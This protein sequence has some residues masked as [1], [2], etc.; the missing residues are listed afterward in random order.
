MFGALDAN[1]VWVVGSDGTVLRWDGNDWISQSSGTGATLRDIW[2]TDANSIWAV[3]NDGQGVIL[4]WNGTAWSPA[5]IAERTGYLFG[6]W[7]SDAGNAWAVGEDGTILKWDGE[8]WS[9]QDSVTTVTLF[10]PVVGR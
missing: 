1:N 4:H 7:G 3:G 2:G 9:P 8:T 5:Q 10:L 6:V